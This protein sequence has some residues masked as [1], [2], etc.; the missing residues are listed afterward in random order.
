MKILYQH[1][2][3]KMKTPTIR[4]LYTNIQPPKTQQQKPS[5]PNDEIV[6]KTIEHLNKTPEFLPKVG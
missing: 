5:T 1:I 3:L 4:D 6:A 2:K